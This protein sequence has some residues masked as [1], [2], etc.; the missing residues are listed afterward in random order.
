M[1]RGHEGVGLG[2]SISLGLA[3]LMGGDLVVES[4]LGKGSAFRLRLPLKIAENDEIDQKGN[5]ITADVSKN[6]MPKILIAEDSGDS[7]E[8]VREMLR[9]YHA[10]VF[11]ARDGDEAIRMSRE[12]D[13]LDVVLMDLRMH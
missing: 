9:D 3:R 4:E 13:D 6:R 7:Y 12:I 1:S 10:K 8:V 11:W 2:L 5:G